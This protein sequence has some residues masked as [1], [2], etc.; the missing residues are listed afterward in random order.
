MHVGQ[1]LETARSDSYVGVAA[2]SV[3]PER[4]ASPLVVDERYEVTLA[5]NASEINSALR[6]RHQVFKVEIGS[7]VTETAASG[8]EYDEH[9]FKCRHLIVIDRRTGETVGTYRVNTIETAGFPDRFYSASEFTIEDLPEDVL[10]NGVEIGRACIAREHRNTRVL[11][12]LWKA[13]LAFLRS[14]GKR[15]FFGCCSI[16]T[17]DAEVGRRAIWRLSRNGHL[18]EQFRVLPKRN[19]LAPFT[20]DDGLDVELPPLFNMYLRLGARVCGPPM[21]DLEFG[22]IDFFVVF[23]VQTMNEKYRRMFSK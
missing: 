2:G 21:V 4:D 11:F 5:G 19:G 7:A 15:Y 18:H 8:L 1:T 17:T 22:S 12:L 13:L 14:S 16:F 20:V 10:H 9:D 3:W 6:L 23:D